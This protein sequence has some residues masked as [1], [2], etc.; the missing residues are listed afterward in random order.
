[1]WLV[2]QRKGEHAALRGATGKAVGLLELVGQLVLLSVRP[3][4]GQDKGAAAVR[5]A[6]SCSWPDP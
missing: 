2:S 4:L 6:I 5:P 3:Y 1:M